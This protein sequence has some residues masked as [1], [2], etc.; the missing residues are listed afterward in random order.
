MTKFSR[1]DWGKLTAGLLSGVSFAQSSS[2]SAGVQLGACTYSF[3]DLPRTNG[4]AIG[5]VL[6]ALEKCHVNIC[7]L[8]SRQVEPENGPDAKQSREKM[9]EWR[10][11]SPMDHF[12]SVRK[13]FEG[14]GVAIFAYTV[15]FSK[16]F[17]DPELDK[18]FQQA[19]ALRAKVI[20]SSTKVSM[21][22]R[23]KP[24]AEK[25]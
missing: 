17:T 3:R 14:S 25:Y 19:K 23:L 21:L 2:G 6:D 16:D 20:A 22:P 13:R 15:N 4:D 5:P 8:F 24:L 11:N 1:R 10:V 12:E 7:E 18:S 9:R